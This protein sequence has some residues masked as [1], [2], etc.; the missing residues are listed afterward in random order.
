MTKRIIPR[1]FDICIERRG[2]RAVI[3]GVTDISGVEYVIPIV[4]EIADEVGRQ[5][6]AGALALNGALA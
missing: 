4:P 1:S 3:L 5:L 6:L 2:G